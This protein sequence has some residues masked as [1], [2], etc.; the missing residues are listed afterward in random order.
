M[1]CDCAYEAHTIPCVFC[2]ISG[3]STGCD[4]CSGTMA[5]RYAALCIHCGHEA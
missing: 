2:N 1:P 4:A 5:A 3:G